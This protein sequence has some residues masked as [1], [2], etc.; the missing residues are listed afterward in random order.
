MTFLST[1]T[2]CCS[3]LLLQLLAALLSA[4]VDMKNIPHVLTVASDDNKISSRSA[5]NDDHVRSSSGVLR[6]PAAHS[7][8]RAVI[9][10]SSSSSSG[11]PSRR[12]AV[13]TPLSSSSVSRLHITLSCNLIASV[14]EGTDETEYKCE[15]EEIV[16]SIENHSFEFEE[17]LLHPD[18]LYSGIQLDI[19]GAFI[20]DDGR[21]FVIP[22]DAVVGFF[23]LF[24]QE[25]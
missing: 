6:R 8:S 11:R 1:V 22:S 7:S 17:L 4:L 2:S 16:Y 5:E 3:L 19:Q 15:H 10:P 12:H 23:Q 25:L 14:D 9:F 20:S 13:L 24:L 18:K 21:Y